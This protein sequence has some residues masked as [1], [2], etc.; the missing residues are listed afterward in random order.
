MP[1]ESPS[2][3]QNEPLIARVRTYAEIAIEHD[4]RRTGE[5]RVGRAQPL[6]APGGGDR[7]RCHCASE[8]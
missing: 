4:Q 7:D 8:G 6:E 1:T 5:Q 2:S 3:I